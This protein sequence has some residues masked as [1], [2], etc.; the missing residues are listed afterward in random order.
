M[1]D[2]DPG[3]TAHPTA[4]VDDGARIG[5]GTRIWHWTHVSSG[6]VIGRG[7]SLGQN[8]FV[9]RTAIIGDHVKVQNNVS[10]YDGVILEDGVFCG[11]SCVFTNVN[12]P[13][14][15]IERKN[16]YRRTV[17]R[18]GA[19][20]GAN[21]TIV[22]GHELGAYCFIAAGAVVTS[23]VPPYALMAG[24]PARRI[25][26]MSKAGGKLGPDLICP[27]SGARYRELG[28]DRLEEIAP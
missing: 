13:R 10:I 14:S 21:A 17:V 18:H 5:D 11:P 3:W 26:W 20:I 25:G 19:T 12:N 22:C 7:C 8:V 16:E 9:A 2:G 15:E 23:I 28:P 24:V 1:T 27:I 4:V 6:A